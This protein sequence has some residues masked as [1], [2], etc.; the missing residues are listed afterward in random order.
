MPNEYN[1]QESKLNLQGARDWNVNVEV[2]YESGQVIRQEGCFAIMFTNIG[3]TTATVCGFI[4]YP[5]TPGS[6]LGD[7]RTISGH[8]LDLYKGFINVIIASPPNAEPAVEVGQFF[9]TKQFYTK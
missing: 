6:A 8:L 7:S 3:D 1:I 9:Y 2:V 5:G 4:I